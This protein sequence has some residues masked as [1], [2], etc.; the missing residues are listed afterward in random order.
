[1]NAFLTGSRVYGEPSSE[2]DVDLAVLLP[3]DEICKLRNLSGVATG[4]ESECPGAT[5]SIRFGNLNIIATHIDAEFAAWKLATEDLA[6]IKPVPK[7]DCCKHFD[8][9]RH[10]R[11]VERTP[12][13]SGPLLIEHEASLLDCDWA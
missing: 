11:V 2:S 1:M 3:Y 7:Q 9:I 8:K 6:K 13:A 12:V 10:G 5:T 4:D